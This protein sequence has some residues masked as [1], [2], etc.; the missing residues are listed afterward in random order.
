MPELA[1]QEVYA[2]NAVEARKRL[3][4]TYLETQSIAATARLWRPSRQVV[5]KSEAAERSRCNEAKSVVK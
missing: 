4:Q 1:Y 2:M 3:I 5:R